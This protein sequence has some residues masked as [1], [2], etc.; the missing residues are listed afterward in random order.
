MDCTTSYLSY[1]STNTFSK[2]VIDYLHQ[3][4]SIQPFYEHAPTLTGISAAINSRKNINT[5]R[6]LLVNTLNK[7]YNGII[8]SNKVQA[9]IDLLLNEHVYTVTTAHQPNVFTGPMYFIYKIMHAVKLADEIALHFPQN[10]FVPVY[11]MG[12][13][14]ADLEELGTIHVG[15]RRL[16]W[17][18]NQTGAVG[19][20]KVDKSFLQMM[21]SIEGQIGVLPFGEELISLY[22]NC[23]TEGKLIQQATL[24]LVNQLFAEFGIVVIIPDQAALKSTFISVIK[25]ELIEQFSHSIVEKTASSLSL[26]YKVQASGRNINLFYLIDHCRERIELNSDGHFEIKALKIIF[27]KDEIL[28]ELQAHPERFSPNVILRGIFQ[29]TVLPN[30]AF[31]GGGG[32]L[33]YWLELK[34]VFKAVNIPYPVLVL[35]NSFLLIEKAQK[36][37]LAK[38]FL[39]EPDLFMDSLALINRTVK[40]NSD[41]QLSLKDELTAINFFYQQLA[42]ISSAIDITLSDH[43]ISIKNNALKR[44]AQLEKKMLRAEKKKFETTIQQIIRLKSSLFPD[45]ILQERQENFSIFYSKYGSNWLQIIYQASKGLEQKFGV[46]YFD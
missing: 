21:H 42:Q 4:D 3:A 14:D 6:A 36:E 10:Q 24:E 18:T 9:N 17:N 12:C 7:Q 46:I 1:D 35:R 2:I 13:E 29:E 34:N 41:H 32:E 27:T 8:I 39:S 5:N 28:Q 31:V 20:M 37:K 44:V 30:I 16:V 22:K 15:G 43:V 26:N 23:Y 33:A 45:N 40:A 19:R 11:Y 25:K 38:L